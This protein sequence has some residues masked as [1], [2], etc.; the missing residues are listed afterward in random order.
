MVHRDIKLEN[1]LYESKTT[2]H[3]KLID[4][5]FS[6]VWDVNTMMHMSCGTLSYVAPEVLHKKYT[7]QCD[8]WS[9][10]VVIF[11]LLA[12]YMPFSGPD[13]KQVR[14]IKEGKFTWKEEKWSIISKHGRE[15]VEKLMTVNPE[16]R[17]TAVL[18]LEHPWIA[19][20]QEVTHN[21]L[22][23]DNVRAMIAFSQESKFRRQCML[24]MAWSLSNEERAKLR[25][26]F[27]AMDKENHGTITL[28]Q[29]KQCVEEHFHLP[30]DQVKKVFE[31]LDAAHN[32]EIQY[33]EFLA[34]MVSSRIHLYDSFLQTAFK[35]FDTDASGFV[36]LANLK[37]VLGDTVSAADLN[38]IMNEV[39]ENHDGK[40]SFQE[41]TD[42]VHGSNGKVQL[43][44]HFIEQGV[45]NHPGDS[46]ALHSKGHIVAKQASIT[47]K[48]GRQTS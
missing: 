11:I 5:G 23:D 20:R 40:I 46:A 19:N 29:F 38:T 34:A 45:S 47:P 44:D 27:M 6:K 18:A 21:E 22:S 32:G 42:Y 39:D 3:L 4:F 36:T 37:E 16:Q 13:E 25:S 26:A 48:A 17:L 15:F 2:D 9:L 7:S 12:G 10:G 28:P 14:C 35:R 1:W 33:T 8:M 24:A 43:L 41:F 30:D 31:S